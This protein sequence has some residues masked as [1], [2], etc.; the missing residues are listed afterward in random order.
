MAVALVALLAVAAVPAGAQ[1]LRAGNDGWSTPG[2]GQTMI[3]FGGYPDVLGWGG[4]PPVVSIKGKALD[5]ANLGSIDTLLERGGTVLDASGY[6]SAAL[7]VVALSLESEGDFQVN[8]TWYHLNITLADNAKSGKISLTKINS[9]GGTFSSSFPVVP[10]LSFTTGGSEVAAI[11][12]ANV[13]C[14]DTTMT[15]SN[16]AWSTALG[17]SF[18][19]AAQGVTP[20]RAG[21]TVQG[22]KTI[23]SNG[24]VVPGF[25]PDKGAGFPVATI[26]EQDRWAKHQVR[27]VQDCKKGGGTASASAASSRAAAV[28]TPIAVKL[29][30][31]VATP[32]S[33]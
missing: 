15:S 21:I 2:G 26:T 11:D 29:C 13:S 12:C 14:P 18:D 9:D 5:S 22:Y 30:D 27:P 1:T 10:R 19:P 23:G 25:T 4:S 7:R 17:G 6:G 33:D 3:D 24:D 32:A 16:S 20:I 31:A 28:A 8:G